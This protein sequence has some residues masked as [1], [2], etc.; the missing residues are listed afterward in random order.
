MSI[1]VSVTTIVKYGWPFAILLWLVACKVRWKAYP[2]EAIIIEKRGDNLIK[3]YDRMGKY[4]DNFSGMTGYMLMKA[5]DTVPVIDFDWILHNASKPTNILE[6][7]INIL[8][9]EMGTVFLFRYGSKQ[10][11]PLN[12]SHDINAQLEWETIKGE[13]G[14]DIV[15]QR[16]QQYDP[17]GTLKV[18]NFEV[19]DWDNMNFMVQEMRTSFER[20]Q[21]RSAWIKEVAV[22]MA[23]VAATALVCIIM[24]KFGFDYAQTA[25]KVQPP[26]KATVPNLPG[27]GSVTPGK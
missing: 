7:L 25:P 11:K 10:Y 3:T 15:V 22:P 26:T 21:K 24:I 13:D 18:L 1:L 2:L 9:P 14:K 16:Y 20:R 5:G 27:A 8:R 17:R 6:K 4:V 23:M 19:V 12:P